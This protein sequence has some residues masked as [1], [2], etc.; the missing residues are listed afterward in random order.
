MQALAHE[1]FVLC[2]L[3]LHQPAPL[4]TGCFSPFC[5][6]PSTPHRPLLPFLSTLTIRNLCK[7]TCTGLAR[8]KAEA[9]GPA[10]GSA[11]QTSSLPAWA[12]CSPYCFPLCSPRLVIRCPGL[13]RNRVEGS[14]ALH[15]WPNIRK[16]VVWTFDT[17]GVLERSKWDCVEEICLCERPTPTHNCHSCSAIVV[18]GT[19]EI[20]EKIRWCGATLLLCVNFTTL[21]LGST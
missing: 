6:W 8:G 12:L 2:I 20:Q 15:W 21:G 11:G 13:S 18:G 5:S 1:D 17:S 16:Q 14:L 9:V 3:F 19:D 10:A 4:T 7:P